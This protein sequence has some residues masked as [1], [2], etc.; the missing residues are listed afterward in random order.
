[1]RPKQYLFISW[2]QTNNKK[3]YIELIN[4]FYLSRRCIYML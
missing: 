4:M 2:I 1:M 3:E